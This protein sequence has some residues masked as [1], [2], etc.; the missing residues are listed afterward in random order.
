MIDWNHRIADVGIML[1]EREAWRHGIATDAIGIVCTIAREE[2]RLR[3]LSAGC[4]AAND[5]SRKAFAHAG[6]AVEAVRKAHMLLEGRP[7]DVVVMG[8]Q[9]R[10]I[11]PD[12]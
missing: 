4:D 11:N 9:L 1:G 12:G 6:F 8:S 3:K 7:E 2:F 10:T 5:A